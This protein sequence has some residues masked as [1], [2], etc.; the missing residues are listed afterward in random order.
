MVKCF[1]CNKMMIESVVEFT[2]KVRGEEFTFPAQGLICECGFR[3]VGPE[4]M[5]AYD[6]A[7]ADAYRSKHNLLTNEQL[8]NCRA[9]TK[10]SQKEFAGWLG[11]H[12]QSIKRW[13]H[14]CVQDLAMDQLIR[15]KLEAEYSTN[16]IPRKAHIPEDIFDNLRI[17]LY[18]IADYITYI[19]Q[20]YG[21]HI[22]P[23]KL[24]KLSYYAQAWFL[25]FFD[26]PLF[27][28]EF[29]AWSYGPVHNDMYQKYKELGRKP[30]PEVV[31]LPDLP[32]PIREHVK[33]VLNVYAVYTAFGLGKKT[34]EERPWQEARGDLPE[35]ALCSNT[36]TKEAMKIYYREKY[37]DCR[38][39]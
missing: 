14:G 11:V 21:E 13:E 26:R 2:G 9:L 32:E 30:I 29:Q 24:Q 33:N 3:T 19:L 8:K 25:A 6:I 31:T 16:D 12:A 17:C 35:D 38:P 20:D 36:I 28:E 1:E 7:L 39:F 22:S 5:E 10:M 4:H 18:D 34:H 37:Q 15:K 27:V 23:M